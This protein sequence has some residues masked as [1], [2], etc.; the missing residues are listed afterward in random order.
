VRLRFEAASNAIESGA[1]ASGDGK[2]MPFLPSIVLVRGIGF[3]YLKETLGGGLSSLEQTPDNGAYDAPDSASSRIVASTFP[4]IF[5]FNS[6]H[7]RPVV[8]VSV[9]SFLS[10]SPK[11][12]LVSCSSEG[13]GDGEAGIPFAWMPSLLG[14]DALVFQ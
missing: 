5:R 12:S 6:V 13:G 4:P 2:T 8:V 3:S 14:G 10:C 7:Q 1:S 11:A 9:F